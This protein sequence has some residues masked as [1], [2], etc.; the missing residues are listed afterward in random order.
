MVP[1]ARKENWKK[2]T[3]VGEDHELCRGQ[4]ESGVALRHPRD[5]EQ[6]AEYIGMR[7]KRCLHGDAHLYS[8]HVDRT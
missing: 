8:S 4:V 2:T 3:V 6:A 7:L 5:V 1:L